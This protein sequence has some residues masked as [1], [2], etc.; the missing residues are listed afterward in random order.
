VVSIDR[1]LAVVALNPAVSTTLAL[2][3]TLILPGIDQLG[4]AQQ[5]RDLRLQLRLRPLR[6]RS[7]SG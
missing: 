7:P 6:R 3:E 2:A 5:R 4:L 1:H